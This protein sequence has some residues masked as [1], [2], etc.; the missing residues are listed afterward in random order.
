MGFLNS[1]YNILTV[2]NY[3]CTQI[4]I[5]YLIKNYTK[6]TNVIAKCIKYINFY[7]FGI[8]NQRFNIS[9]R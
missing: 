2:L 1:L 9:E 6:I 8:D 3:V 7:F 4:S 5:F